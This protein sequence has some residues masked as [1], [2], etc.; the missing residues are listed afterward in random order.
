MTI[1]ISIDDNLGV[2]ISLSLCSPLHSSDEIVQFVRIEAFLIADADAA[3]R[4]FPTGPG[5]RQ[6]IGT[7][8]TFVIASPTGLI[9]VFGIIQTI[10]HHVQETWGVAFH[11]PL[12]VRIFLA[13]RTFALNVA[14]MLLPMLLSQ[15]T[16]FLPGAFIP[17]EL[18]IVLKQLP[19]PLMRTVSTIHSHIILHILI[20]NRIDAE[21]TD[22]LLQFLSRSRLFDAPDGL[23]QGVRTTPCCHVDRAFI[24][25]VSQSD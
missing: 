5:R 7:K 16:L 6:R 14:G 10:W 13:Q 15:F 25:L 19:Q 8:S 3:D 17:N 4:I 11:A 2:P 21:L 23:S 12:I 24:L 18:Q 22:E 1:G 9:R 20:R